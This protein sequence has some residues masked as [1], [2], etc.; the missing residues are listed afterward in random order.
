MPGAHAVVIGMM[1]RDP[2]QPK[3]EREEKQAPRRQPTQPEKPKADGKP[4]NTR[5]TNVLANSWDGENLC[6]QVYHK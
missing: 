2:P 5:N 3:A 1:F 4:K 6:P